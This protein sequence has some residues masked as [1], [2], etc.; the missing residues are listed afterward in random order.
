MMAIKVFSKSP[1]KQAIADVQNYAL[2]HDE[3][4]M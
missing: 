2:K 3:K 4:A 1:I